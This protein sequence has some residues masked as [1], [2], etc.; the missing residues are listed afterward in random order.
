M[1]E[2]ERAT[3]SEAFVDAASVLRQAGIATPELDARL[4]LCHAAGL[5][6]E[7]FIAK[8]RDGVCPEAA[9][10]LAGL[11]ARRLKREP[12]SRILGVREFYGREFLVDRHA[13][14]PRPDTETLIE[15][16]LDLVGRAASRESP[17][18]LL[19]LGTGT[20]CI[21]ITL[22][23]EMPH[24]RAVGT[25]ISGAALK[26]AAANADRLGVADRATFVAANW[27]DGVEGSFDL[28]LSN[29]PYIA[30]AQITN[31]A[32]E[33]AAH[34]PRLALD[35][36]PDGLDAYRRIAALAGQVL[37]PAGRI[38]VEIGPD[39]AAAVADILGAAGFSLDREG[40]VR[41]DLAGRPR[42]VVAE[43]RKKG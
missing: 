4:L 41:V 34:D 25:D 35:G 20:G 11:I 15:A 2:T 24:A 10:R 8:A 27:L 16:A 14:D 7:A 6:H 26:L 29:P 38:L 39:Q 13:L 28:I 42:L 12:V 36:G 5:S 31:L 1:P 18:K 23:A 37:A 40:N 22:L 9:T 32:R 19:D 30:S 33:V 43:V 21:L 17:L 3:L